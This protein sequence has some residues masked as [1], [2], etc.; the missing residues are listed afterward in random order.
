[1]KVLVTGVFGQLGYDVVRCLLSLNH[2]VI[3]CGRADKNKEVFVGKTV[4][5]QLDITEPSHIEEVIIEEKPDA[6]IHCA[7]WTAVDAAEL[8]ENKREVLSTNVIATTIIAKMAKQ[9]GAKLVYIST[10]YVFDGTGH[11]AWDPDTSM[12][13]PINYYGF[14]KFEGERSVIENTEAYFIVRISWVFGINGSNFVKTMLRLASTKDYLTIVDDQIGR[15]TYTYDLAEL[16][17]SMISS[18]EYGIYHACNEGENISWYEF[19]KEIFRI[20]GLNIK[21]DPIHS[22][23]YKGATA[24]RPYN[25]RLSTEKIKEKF[26]ALP[27]WK[28]ALRR[29]INE[30]M[31]KEATR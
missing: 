19:A 11:S 16:L 29:F 12:P 14:S 27:E 8:S 4:Y 13:S 30:Y 25:S 23:E 18:E 20:S 1:M 10:D 2:E 17:S 31:G 7:A 5:R 21:V 6:I 15:P 26:F 22:D 28:D 9:V 24:K 3:C